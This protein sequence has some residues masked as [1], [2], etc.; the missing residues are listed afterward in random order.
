MLVAR[1]IRAPHIKKTEKNAKTTTKTAWNRQCQFWKNEDNGYK[2]MKVMN[3]NDDTS[4]DM[5]PHRTIELNGPH[6][7]DPKELQNIW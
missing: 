2:L 4:D 1:G 3:V 7:N 5:H 6:P